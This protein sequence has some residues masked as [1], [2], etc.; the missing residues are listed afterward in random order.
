MKYL[1]YLKINTK[2]RACHIL[3]NRFLGVLGQHDGFPIQNLCLSPDGNVCASISHDEYVKFW[4]VENIK[5]IKIDA[6]SKS[7]S[8]SL[9]D[10]KLTTKGKSDNFFSDLFENGEDED[11]ENDSLDEDDDSDDD[12]NDESG[13]DDSDD[14][15]SD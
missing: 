8:K 11:D 13:S 9:K 3:P 4:N 7:K 12:S 1:L 14:S 2:F 15:D 10:K 5:S 6:Q